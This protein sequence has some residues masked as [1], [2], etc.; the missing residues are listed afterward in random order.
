MTNVRTRPSEGRAASRQAAEQRR[1]GRRVLRWLALGLAFLLLA[2]CGGGYWYYQH[3]NG[4]FDSGE[5]NLSDASGAR[6]A[7]NAAGQTPINILMIG[8]DNRG[9]AKNIAL[10]GSADDAG[11]PGLADVQMLLHVSADRSNASLISIPRDTLVTIP[12]CRS[13][14]GKTT[15]PSVRRTMINEALARGGPGCLLGTWQAITGLYIDH[16]MMIDFAGVVDMADAV[17]GVP[18][19]VNM[20]LYDRYRKGH[21]GTDLKLAKGTHRIQGEQALQWLRTRDAWG[22]DIGRTKAQHLYLSSMVRELKSK[23]TLT[24]PGALLKLAET[25]SKSISLDKDL[26][27]VKALLDLGTDLRKVPTERIT[28]LTVPTVTATSDENRLELKE[29]D[30]RQIWD[31]LLADRP[32]DDKGPAPSS[33]PTPSPTPSPSAGTAAPSTV[34]VTVQNS[35]GVERRAG[36]V[37][38]AL[39]AKGFTKAATTAN[40]TARK[41][42][43]LEYPPQQSAEAQA[44]AAALG[45]PR[46]ALH[47]G[48]AKSEL[49]LSVGADWPSGT[50]FPVTAPPTQLPK[51]AEAVT[52]DNDKNCMDVNPQGGLY[53]F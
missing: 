42:T 30:T 8:T 18:V 34:A 29:Q 16:Y 15:K 12:A 7:P 31:M 11:R 21:G 35:S 41:T 27:D 25:A 32:L 50:A 13:E 49:L 10:G 39:V 5:R 28:T 26:A 33:S 19:C 40:G 38:A 37:R 22:D 45:L 20:N 53:T 14:D 51:S 24:D 23:G 3:L 48:T 4:N 9:S 47:E 43:Q 44:V 46:T 36:D 17:G 6:T 1:G 2:A 52:A